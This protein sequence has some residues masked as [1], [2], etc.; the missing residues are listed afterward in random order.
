MGRQIERGGDL[1]NLELSPCSSI[2][3]WQGREVRG[4]GVFVKTLAGT[5]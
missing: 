1:I 5:L 4:S 3:S 2:L